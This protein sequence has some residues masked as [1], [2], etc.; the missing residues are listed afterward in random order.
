MPLERESTVR[1]SVEHR[2]A[3]P[4]PYREF[5]ATSFFSPS[6]SE[7]SR[8]QDVVLPQMHFAHGMGAHSSDQLEDRGSLP[9]EVSPV[10]IFSHGWPRPLGLALQVFRRVFRLGASYTDFLL[11]P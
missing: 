9:V 1:L 8:C 7:K 4:F 10:R 6:L 5:E 11:F 2:P 3:L